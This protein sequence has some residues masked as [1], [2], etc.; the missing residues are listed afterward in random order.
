MV[1]RSV[2]TAFFL[3]SFLSYS[4]DVAF[5]VRVVDH[6]TNARLFE[7]NVS[8]YQDSNLIDSKLTDS[9][10]IVSLHLSPEKEYKIAISANQKV[11][12][13]FNVD[14]TNCSLEKA[15]MFSDVAGSCQVG[16]FVEKEGV[17]YSY[18]INNP[19]TR[20]YL[21]DREIFLFYD[22]GMAVKMN[23]EIERIQTAK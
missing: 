16:L 2:F 11:T 21:A 6:V 4:Q 7:A 17:D 1:L 12:R 5:E 14:L 10:G 13:F 23:K 9:L 19:I 18:V 20:F 15:M 22:P 3:M 8:V